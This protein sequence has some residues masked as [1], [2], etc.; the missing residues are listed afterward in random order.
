MYN[1]IYQKFTESKQSLWLW[2]WRLYVWCSNSCILQRYSFI[3][4]LSL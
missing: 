2:D 1:R 3:S 4:W